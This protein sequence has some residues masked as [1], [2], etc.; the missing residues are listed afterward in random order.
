MIG[1]MLKDARKEKGYTMSDIQEIT[2]I[3]APNYCHY[4][5][6][7]VAP[8]DHVII[9]KLAN[10]LGLD[11]DALE[12]ISSLDQGKIPERLLQDKGFMEKL[13]SMV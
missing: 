5:S 1:Q 6:E 11:V 4:E 7:M 9:V 2:G 12:F 13:Y 8:V 10:A 3:K